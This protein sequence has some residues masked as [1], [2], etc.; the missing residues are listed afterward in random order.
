MNYVLDHEGKPYRKIFEDISRIPR[1]SF[2]EEAIADYVVQWA[3]DRNLRYHRDSHHNVII[4]KDAT[5]GFEGHETVMLQGHMDMIWE[6]RP[7]ST[8]DF[9]T[10]PIELIEKDGYLMA[11]E[12]TCG[13]D[14]GVAV[15]YMLA[16]LDEKDWR[17]PALECVFTTAEEAGCIGAM[18]LDATKLNAKKM[19]SMDGNT[20][21]T[22]LVMTAGGINGDFEKPISREPA[23]THTVIEL[24]VSGLQGGHSANAMNREGANAIKALAR[25]LHYMR[26]EG[27]VKIADFHGGTVSLIPSEALAQVI[28]DYAFA[29]RALEIAARVAQEIAE[30]HADSDPDMKFSS[31]TYECECAP[32][33]AEASEQLISL[34]YMVPTGCVNR[35]VV[36][37]NVPFTS[38]NLEVIT[39]TDSL[40]SIRY[41]PKSVIKSKMLDMEEQL[42]VLAGLYGFEYK[43]SGHYLGHYLPFGSPLSRIY[44]EVYKEETS[45]D[46]KP[47]GVHFGNEI[48]LF[49]DMIPGLDVIVLVA[50]H[51]AAHTPD[52]KLDI[53]SFDRCYVQLKKLL[54]RL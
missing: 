22:T 39:T 4:Y 21:G 24:Q 41:K 42:H 34:L 25:M 7:G 12:T 16:I 6:K 11:K 23:G 38:A 37:P 36:Y 5:P 46:L 44:A 29:G 33:S 32:M 52:E 8:F 1:G 35:S 26:K 14:D 9:K 45:L 17:H 15:A 47:V 54:E 28:V 43:T 48:G 10:Q 30:E 51:F 49:R 27:S 19:I 53:A 18:Y 40:I 50:T 3:V 31:R 13:S 20:E 2:R